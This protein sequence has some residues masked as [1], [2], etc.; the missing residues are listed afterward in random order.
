MELTIE[1]ALQQGVTAHNTG[2]LQE[3]E[4]VYQ[5]ILR[6]DPKHPD[7]SHNLGLI[8]ISMNHIEAA[9]P[10][11]KTA[12]EV[13]PMIEHF[14]VSY[15]DT[16]VKANRLKDA[17]KAIK[18]AKKKGFDAKKL[19]VLLSQSKGRADIKVPS[20]EQLSRLLKCYQ[21]GKYDDT[22]QLALSIIEKFPKHQVAWKILASVSKIAG[23]LDDSLVASQNSVQLAS[24]DAEAHF[25]LGNT[26]KDLGR[27]DEAEVSFTQAIALKSDFALAHNN[28][29]IMLQELNRLEEAEANLKQAIAL[30]P[31]YVNAHYNLGNTLKELG[32]FDEAQ[33]NFTQAIALKPD[34][35]EAHSNLGGMLQ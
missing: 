28:L 11:F 15:I 34:Y 20:E 31:D 32:R 7:A 24:Q 22:E 9:L 13:N 35:A 21:D 30:R 19:Q 23:R 26:L 12:L 25:N 4:R 1:Q 10:L 5:G 2:N 17:K 18:K 29:G 14:W 8:A 6:S 16:L 3:A 27:L 33:V